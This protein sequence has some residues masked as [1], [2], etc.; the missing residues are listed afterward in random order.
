[1]RLC[2]S[3]IPEEYLVCYQMSQR[4]WV[5]IKMLYRYLRRCL[6]AFWEQGSLDLPACGLRRGSNGGP[7]RPIFT[8]ARPKTLA[9]GQAS[10][11]GRHGASSGAASS[12]WLT[13]RRRDQGRV[14]RDVPMTQA[15]KTKG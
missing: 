10:R 1:M 6:S 3:R 7:A 5:I 12:G 15:M 14:P 8:N 9:R 13:R 2:N 11:G 4:D